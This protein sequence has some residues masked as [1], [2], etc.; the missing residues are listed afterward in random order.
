MNFFPL[1]RADLIARLGCQSGR[2]LDK[3]AAFGIEVIEDEETLAPVLKEAYAAYECECRVVDRHTYGDHDRSWAK[4]C[5][6]I[7]GKGLHSGVAAGSRAGVPR[8]LCGR[9]PVS[10]AR[11]WFAGVAPEPVR[12]APGGCFCTTAMQVAFLGLK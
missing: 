4:S 6:S 8:P 5:A 12:R 11:P 10:G 3:F 7:A 9:Q 2:D 1:E